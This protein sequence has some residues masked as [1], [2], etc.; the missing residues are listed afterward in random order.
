MELIKI[1]RISTKGYEEGIAYYDAKFS[2]V[3]CLCLYICQYVAHVNYLDKYQLDKIRK[4]IIIGRTLRGCYYYA[5][6][7]VV[8][9]AIAPRDKGVFDG[10]FGS[11]YDFQPFT[12][13]MNAE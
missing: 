5:N 2:A 13:N 1:N 4:K 3:Y 10:E 7:E 12:P 9:G 11:K 6:D 8:Y